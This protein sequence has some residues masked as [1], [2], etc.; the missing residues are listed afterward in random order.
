[1][2]A[3]LK[4]PGR[5]RPGRSAPGTAPGQRRSTTAHVTVAVLLLFALFPVMWM[6]LTAFTSNEDIFHF[7]PSLQRSFT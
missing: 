4:A 2:S 3:T 6:A 7:P 5:A 1:M